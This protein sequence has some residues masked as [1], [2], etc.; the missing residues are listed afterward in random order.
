MVGSNVKKFI[1]VLQDL[2]Q[3][4]GNVIDI[5]VVVLCYILVHLQY[6]M[7]HTMPFNKYC[8]SVFEKRQYLLCRAISLSHTIRVTFVSHCTNARDCSCLQSKIFFIIISAYLRSTAGLQ[9]PPE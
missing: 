5:F 4:V 1:S 9:P 6:T 3:N 8:T 2:L 7:V